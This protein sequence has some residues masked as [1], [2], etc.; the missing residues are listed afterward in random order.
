MI[1]EEH[2]GNIDVESSLYEGSKFNISLP[3]KA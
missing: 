1:V 2:N 3:L